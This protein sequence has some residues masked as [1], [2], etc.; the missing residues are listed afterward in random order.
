M[1]KIS[2]YQIIP[3]LK[4]GCTLPNINNGTDWLREAINMMYNRNKERLK[5]AG[6]LVNLFH[7]H[8]EESGITISRY[9]LIQFQ[10]ILS[11]YYVVGINDGCIALKEL[12]V[13]IQSVI[14]I[15]EQLSIAV[16]KVTESD[17]TAAETS[18][19]HTYKISN[20]LPFSSDNY[21]LY[22]KMSTLSEK[23]AFLEHNIKNHLVKDFSH[24]L[25][26]NFRDQ[27]IHVH[28]TWIDS[29]T[30]SCVPVKV[31]KHIHDFQPFTIVFSANL[32]LPKH[33]CLGNG[34]VYGFG[35]VEPAP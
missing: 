33:I 32:L 18:E 10:K 5:E 28:L 20:W 29:F 13:D 25:D 4:E 7:N 22:L 14:R 6:V 15:T 35:I 2:R 11:E 26:L 3:H 27:N 21:K 12:F 23:V 8:D 34:K 17:Q 16:K 30:R 24:Y 1:I 9:P 19:P 31:N